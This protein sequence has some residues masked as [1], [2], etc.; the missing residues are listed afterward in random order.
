MLCFVRWRL[1]GATDVHVVR[2]VKHGVVI[3][4]TPR[5]VD[6]RKQW[7]LCIY[8]VLA[9]YPF[10]VRASRSLVFRASAGLGGV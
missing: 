1:P 6:F 9:W 4:K 10:T 2:A 8:N 7:L 3:M 5:M